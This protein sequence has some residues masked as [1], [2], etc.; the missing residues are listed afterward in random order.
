M[1]TY[2]NF[3]NELYKTPILNQKD[4]EEMVDYIEK[5]V[6]ENGYDIYRPRPMDLGVLMPDMTDQRFDKN[7]PYGEEEWEKKKPVLMS[8]SMMVFPDNKPHSN[9]ILA[10]NYVRREDGKYFTELWIDESDFK[11]IGLDML[12]QLIEK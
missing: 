12:K 8:N 4:I 3:V 9:R 1:K 6:E 5:W 2:E 11:N 7:D 10:F